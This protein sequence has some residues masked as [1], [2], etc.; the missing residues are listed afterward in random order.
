MVV[1]S[2]AWESSS[3]NTWAVTTS[4]EDDDDVLITVTVSYH[5]Q[6]DLMVAENE[7]IKNERRIKNA[8]HYRDYKRLGLTRHL[9][10]LYEARSVADIEYIRTRDSKIFGLARPASLGPVRAAGNTIELHF[11]PAVAPPQFDL[12]GVVPTWDTPDRSIERSS[13]RTAPGST[14]SPPQSQPTRRRGASASGRR[15]ARP[16]PR[17]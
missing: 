5:A 17:S 1:P 2:A 16:S 10:I 7:L 4:E 15:S 13:P 14:S 8:A 6:K 9:P 3:P 12:R 11:M